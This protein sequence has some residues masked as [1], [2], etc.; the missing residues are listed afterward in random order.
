MNKLLCKK[1]REQFGGQLHLLI[2]G[3]A[4]LSASLQ[5]LIKAALD[6]KLVQGYGMTET[7]GACICM[8][9]DDLSYGRCGRPLHGVHAKLDDWVEG[10]YRVTDKPYPRGEL[11]IGSK[12]NSL[13]YL[14]KPE[15]T[16]ELY[17]KDD[18]LGITWF[19]TGDIAEL[20]PD[21]TFKIIDRK[22]DLV[23]LANGEYFSLGKVC[24]VFVDFYSRFNHHFFTLL[25]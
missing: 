19:R 20:H 18:R 14:K 22:K 3:G 24:F 9:E 23:K 21:G 16:A 13:G 12:A 25:D 5:A 17:E 6:V 7:L 8:D 10:D 11:M 2:L 4:P 15:M 1:I